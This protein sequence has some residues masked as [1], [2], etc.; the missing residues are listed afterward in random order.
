MTNQRGNQAGDKAANPITHSLELT[1]FGTPEV[2]LRGKLLSGFRSSKTQAL[3]YFL[4]VSGR[5]QARPTLAGLLWGDQPEAA[6]RVS[7]SKCLSNLHELVGDALTIARQSVAFNRTLPHH[8]DTV[9]VET[10]A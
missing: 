3:L 9:H 2:R 6:T 8:L 10:L 5:A 4:A 1:L 7:L